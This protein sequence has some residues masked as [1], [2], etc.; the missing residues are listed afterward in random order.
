[1]TTPTSSQSEFERRAR[2]AFEAS[3]E[4]LDARTRSRLNQARQAATAELERS[5]RSR[6]ILWAPAGALAAAV[7]VVPRTPGINGA[8]GPRAQVADGATVPVE[9][10]VADDDLAIAKDDDLDFYEWVG[11]QTNPA[12]APAANDIG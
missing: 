5:R 7:L 1:M 10:L 9:V 2:E 6:W 4:G 11:Y 8:E 12:G 3:V